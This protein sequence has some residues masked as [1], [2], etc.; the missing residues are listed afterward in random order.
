M[1]LWR[2]SLSCCYIL[3]IDMCSEKK[4]KLTNVH[5]TRLY[6]KTENAVNSPE[7]GKERKAQYKTS[8]LT[9]K[10]NPRKPDKISMPS[11]CFLRAYCNKK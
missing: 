2:L 3:L 11:F 5:E 7:N 1:S 8:K 10:L 6:N 4:K 9:L